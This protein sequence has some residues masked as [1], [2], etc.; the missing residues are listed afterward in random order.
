[1]D[2]TVPFLANPASFIDKNKKPSAGKG[3]SIFRGIQ[4]IRFYYVLPLHTVVFSDPV[5][6]IYYF[7]PSA[8][9]SVPGS[10]DLLR[11]NHQSF[12]ANPVRLI[13][14]VSPPIHSGEI[15]PS[16]LLC[17][18]HQSFQKIGASDLLFLDPSLGGG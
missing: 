9:S 7:S 5:H 1:M 3:I 6:L 8:F 4:I 13:Y 16:D 18:T 10:S 12:L 11:F 15:G 17:F 2:K 14:Y